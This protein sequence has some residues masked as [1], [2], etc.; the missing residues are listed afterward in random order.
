[1]PNRQILEFDFTA[2]PFF[3]GTIDNPGIAVDFDQYVDF[4]AR[5]TTVDQRRIEDELRSIIKADQSILHVGVGNS[6]L[7]ESFSTLASNIYGVTISSAEKKQAK[8]LGISN[9][10]IFL[11]NKYHRQFSSYFKRLKFDYIIDNNLASFTCCRYHFYQMFDNYISCLKVGGKI[12]TDQ[13]GMDWALA[14]AGFI[15]NFI[16]LK[17]AIIMLPLHVYRMSDMVY[18]LELKAPLDL[19]KESS[20]MVYAKR[21]TK[22]DQVCI[23][24]FFPQVD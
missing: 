22:D 23:E 24:S 12:L 3:C 19:E 7:A 20:F 10:R 18:A 2:T 4:S 9:Y 1:M 15:M 11:A 21:V 13:R 17:M 16:Q 6:A 8:S 14:H 5:E